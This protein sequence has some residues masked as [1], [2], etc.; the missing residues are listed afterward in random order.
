MRVLSSLSTIYFAALISLAMFGCSLY[1]GGT[2]GPPPGLSVV[3]ATDL[4]TF[5]TNPK[6]VGRDGGY[7]GVFA[8]NVVWLYSDTFLT[9]P[10]AQGQTLI[11]DSWA[12][13]TDF[14]ATDGLTGF[15]ERED[16]VGAP[17]MILTLTSAE[18]AF[19]TAH[20]RNPCR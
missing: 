6:I 4:G 17:T 3:Q 8:G 2:S 18:Q 5:G 11:S 1:P 20:Q 9:N 14:N 13:T 19:N 15:Q 10:N 12:F 7:S 16:S